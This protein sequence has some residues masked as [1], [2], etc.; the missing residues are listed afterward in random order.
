MKTL[1]NFL[2]SLVV[3]ILVWFL[4]YLPSLEERLT[5]ALLRNLH[6]PLKQS[7]FSAIVNK[8]V[9][10]PIELAV[11]DEQ[12]RV[13]MFYRRD[14][15]YDGYH[16]PGT[17]LRDNEDVPAAIR[18]LLKS[19]VVGGRVT[20]ITSLGW[21]EIPKGDNPTRHEIS[22]LHSCVLE[23]PYNGKSGEFFFP[24]K[25]PFTTLDHHHTLIKEIM[26]RSGR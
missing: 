5:V 9:S 22:L 12:G 20:Q 3:K 6:W 15:E 13:L 19:E 10:V 11:F 23:G 25:L 2:A 14:D 8:T 16:I 4:K 21:I 24:D 7:I 1:G 18:R 17:V 26:K